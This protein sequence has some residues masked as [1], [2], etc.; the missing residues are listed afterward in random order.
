MLFSSTV[1][2]SSVC[3]VMA[4]ETGQSLTLLSETHYQCC[5]QCWHFLLMAQCL[6][7]SLT[8]NAV[9][10]FRGTSDRC[11][12]HTMLLCHLATSLFQRLFYCSISVGDILCC[13]FSTSSYYLLTTVCICLLNINISWRNL[14]LVVMT[15]LCFSN[16]TNSHNFSKLK[17]YFYIYVLI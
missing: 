9:V 8:L 16:S 15:Y 1:P 7:I 2:W 3:Y 13:V 10:V 4:T 5:Y 12:N 14:S 6:I 11:T 17:Q